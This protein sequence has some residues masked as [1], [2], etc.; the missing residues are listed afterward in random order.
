MHEHPKPDLRDVIARAAEVR[1]EIALLAD[2]AELIGDRAGQL[3]VELT[4]LAGG[5]IEEEEN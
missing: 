2:E 1:R 3:E 4:K 5:E